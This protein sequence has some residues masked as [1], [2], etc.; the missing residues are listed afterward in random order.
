M[1]GRILNEVAF[2]P[3]YMA[4]QIFSIT[5]VQ[6]RQC[7]IQQPPGWMQ[8]CIKGEQVQQVPSSENL[9]VADIQICMAIEHPEAVLGVSHA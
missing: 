4:A 7:P 2:G 9:N 6:N 3:G 5:L 1:P 8:L